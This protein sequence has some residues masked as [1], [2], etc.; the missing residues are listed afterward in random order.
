M[1][2]SILNYTP[3]TVA[4]SSKLKATIAG[5]IYNIIATAQIDNGTII[6]KGNYLRPEVYAEAAATTFTGKII[7]KTATGLWYIEVATAVNAYLT[8]SVPLI[9]EEYTTQCQDESNFY[10][11]AGDTL[12][13]YELVAGDI[14]AISAIGITGTPAINASVTVTAKKVAVV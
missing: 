4:E 9:Y 12:R 3:H 13:A 5:H 2:T 6:G 11:A 8:L 10:N 14:F 7:G 1:A